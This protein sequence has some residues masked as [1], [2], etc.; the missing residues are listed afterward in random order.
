[1]PKSIT[2]LL[3]SY[4]TLEIS[5]PPLRCR[6]A[7]SGIEVGNRQTL[8][9]RDNIEDIIKRLALLMFDMVNRI[10]NGTV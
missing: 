2:E 5:G 7:L 6:Y 3:K 1:M 9:Y 8:I 4:G 10:E